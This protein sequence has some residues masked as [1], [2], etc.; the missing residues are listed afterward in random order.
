MLHGLGGCTPVLNC[1]CIGTGDARRPPSQ[2]VIE[3]VEQAMAAHF[4]GGA[5]CVCGFDYWLIG[6]TWADHMQAEVA[7]AAMDAA[8]PTI[9]AEAYARGWAD[10]TEVVE[11]Q[12]QKVYRHQV[13]EMLPPNWADELTDIDDRSK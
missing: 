9:D 7:K 1:G 5:N 6:P 2:A 12:G 10:A 13:M 3:A 11:F 4:D 8:R